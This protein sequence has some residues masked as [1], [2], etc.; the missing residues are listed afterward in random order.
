MAFE[1]S[2]GLYAGLSF[3]STQDLNA[4]KTDSN[5]FRALYFTALANLRDSTKVFDA[6]GDPTRR[7]MIQ[8]INLGQ[9]PTA[10]KQLAIYSDLAAAISAVLGTRS[11]LRAG[12]KI[13]SRVYLTGNRWH[14]DVGIFK[15]NAFGMADYNSSDVILK[16]NHNDYV[17]ISLKKK[18][19]AR[20]DSPTLIN[21]AFSKF[22]QGP[23]LAST[24]EK[25]NAQ[26]KKFFAEVIK[27]AASPGGPLVTLAQIT[28]SRSIS[29]L[30]PSVDRDAQILWNMKVLIMKNNKLQ[31]IPL[32]NIKKADDAVS[33]DGN[34]LIANSGSDTAQLSFRNF[35]NAKLKSV[36][37]QP[38]PLY[39]DFLDVMNEDSVK[40]KLAGA[41]LNRVLKTGLLD[42]LDTWQSN[43]FGFMLA[44]GVG[45]VN[46]NT[47]DPNIGSANVIDIHSIMIA[48]AKLAR[49]E[50]KMEI[51]DAKMRTRNAA[52]VFF[53]LYKGDTPILNIEL[54][55]KGSFTA[56]PQ[57]FASMT[58]EFK[59]LIR[60]GD[61]GI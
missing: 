29:Q 53:K 18:P 1:P 58:T 2:E 47:L 8:A 48:V 17:G 32:I 57:F 45:T 56:M 26:R 55:Y 52:K 4:A 7:G 61:L 12:D 39:Q 31:S 23:E 34:G 6:P 11:E 30:N 35:V 36:G 38:S 24:R 19:T 43:E 3:V 15:V 41:L 37:G 44:E 27:E 49:E 16:L 50:A 22:I 40:D 9:T 21:N 54:R 60:E 59:S 5:K 46:T 51:D 33:E 28:G 10:K 20:A 42:S 25:L 13:P 14:P